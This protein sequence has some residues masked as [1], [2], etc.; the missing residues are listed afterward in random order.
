[1]INK[2]NK[3][4]KIDRIKL[5]YFNREVSSGNQMTVVCTDIPPEIHAK[6][7]VLMAQQGF[8]SL[9]ELI[10]YILTEYVKNYYPS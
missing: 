1:L 8:P 10:K 5:I 2:L 3:I 9:K 7:R 6:L 4:D